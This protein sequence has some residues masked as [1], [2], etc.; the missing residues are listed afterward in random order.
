L[1]RQVASHNGPAIA[2]GADA[3][4][5]RKYSEADLQKIQLKG[6]FVSIA[7]IRR[8]TFDHRVLAVFIH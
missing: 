6:S 2:Q 5:R 4:G 1:L 3:K 7:I 8:Y